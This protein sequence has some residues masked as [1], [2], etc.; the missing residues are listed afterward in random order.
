MGVVQGG[1]M[2]LGNFLVRTALLAVPLLTACTIEK[3]SE[4]DLVGDSFADSQSEIRQ[5]V[6]SIRDDIQSTNIEGL[7]AAHLESDKFTKFGPRNF[8][9]QDVASA[10]ASEAAFFS[11][12]TNV[13]YEVRDL[14]IDAFGDIGIATYYPEVSFERDGSPVE[15][16]GRQ[17]FVFLKTDA[18]WKLVHEH[19]TVRRP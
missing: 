16:S 13:N 12:I 5:A 8:D 10:N 6:M 9:R 1:V 17:T 19:G 4:I 11:S 15:V 7:Q 14:K 2:R 3:S 18:G